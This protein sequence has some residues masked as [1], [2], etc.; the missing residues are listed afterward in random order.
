MHTEKAATKRQRRREE[1]QKV[2][3]PAKKG[4]TKG[5]GSGILT[6]RLARPSVEAQG[7]SEA[8]ADLENDTGKSK[9]ESEVKEESRSQ[10]EETRARSERVGPPRQED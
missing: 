9:E 6:E 10:A 3:K 7:I 5:R 4:L 1:Q 8:E 2:A